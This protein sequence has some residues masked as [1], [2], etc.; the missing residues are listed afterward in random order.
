MKLLPPKNTPISWIC[1]FD[2]AAAKSKKTIIKNLFIELKIA[3]KYNNNEHS[4]NIK[5]GFML[6]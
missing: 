3:C 1:A 2:E 5:N 4:F 6:K